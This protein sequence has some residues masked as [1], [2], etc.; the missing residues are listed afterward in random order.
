MDTREINLPENSNSPIDWEQREFETAK[1]IMAAFCA[2]SHDTL[3]D[4]RFETMAS[5]SVSG[6]KF[7][8]E[9]YRNNNNK[10]KSHE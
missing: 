9:E 10:I 6:A 2:N 7:L 4:M 5:L 3:V 8:I 1:A